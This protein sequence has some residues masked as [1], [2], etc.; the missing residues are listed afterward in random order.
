Q[1]VKYLMHQ[2][3]IK[4]KSLFLLLCLLFLLKP[5]NAQNS[6]SN[7]VVMYPF[8]SVTVLN[9]YQFING[10]ESFWLTFEASSDKIIEFM[11]P[12][13][14]PMPDLYSVTLLHGSCDSLSVDTNF[15][16]SDST[17]LFYTTNLDSTVNYY[18]HII[19][20]NI[21]QAASFRVTIIDFAL[22][23][24]CSAPYDPCNLIKNGDFSHINSCNAAQSYINNNSYA[25]SYMPFRYNLLCDWHCAWGSPSLGG[26]SGPVSRI[27]LFI[28]G[29]ILLV[30]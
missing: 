5:V 26:G 10:Q 4:Q 7:A 23:P 11:T 29:V 24:T 28:F 22:W 30:V 6:C 20:H 18:L 17:N 12:L 8:D 16:F 3:F 25:F 21:D 1:H 19:R 9:D 13:S 15:Y 27:K 2:M 14:G